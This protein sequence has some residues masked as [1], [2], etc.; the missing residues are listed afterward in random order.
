MNQRW[1]N[2]TKTFYLLGLQNKKGTEI[3]TYVLVLFSLEE[4]LVVMTLGFF[5][6]SRHRSGF[7]PFLSKRLSGSPFSMR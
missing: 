2:V 4:L 5:L 3:Y 6:F 7:D 1:T